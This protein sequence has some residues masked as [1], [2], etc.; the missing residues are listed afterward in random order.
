MNAMV[1]EEVLVARDLRK[2]YPGKPPVEA[3]KGVNLTVRKGQVVALLG[4]NGAG[5]TTLVKIVSGLIQADEGEVFIKATPIRQTSKALRHLSTV[6]EGDRNLRFRLTGL[7]NIQMYLALGGFPFDPRQA[8][9]LAERFGLSDVLAK[10]VRFYS[11]GMKQKLS[12]LIAFLSSAELILLDEPTLGLDV[13]AG[14]ELQSLIRELAQ[15]GRAVLI[16]T[17]EMHVAQKIADWVAI[18]NQGQL[19]AFQPIEALLEM[20]RYNKYLIKFRTG[21]SA[22]LLDRFKA[23]P[24]LALSRVGEGLMTA[25]LSNARQDLLFQVLEL[26]KEDKAEILEIVRYQPD[27]EQVYLTIINEGRHVKAASTPDQ[28]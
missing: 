10:Q 25:T 24:Q 8:Y 19:V 16:T 14:L 15:T 27:L 11:K 12:L 2:C 20:F 21:D 13:H 4:P 7:E 1:Q 28:V 22:T 9:A 5:K 18:L 26:L 6:L 3:L 17:H 23:V